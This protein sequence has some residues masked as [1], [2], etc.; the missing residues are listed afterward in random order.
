MSKERIAFN[1]ALQ[2]EKTYKAFIDQNG[3][4]EEINIPV[5]LN[6]PSN[7]LDIDPFMKRLED[8]FN[9]CE[10]LLKRNNITFENIAVSTNIGFLCK[11]SFVNRITDLSRR[12]D[13]L[14]RNLPLDNIESD[15]M[16]SLINDIHYLIITSLLPNI[17][18]KYVPV[19]FRLNLS[20]CSNPSNEIASASS[21]ED[22][23]KT[24]HEID[25]FIKN[26]SVKGIVDFGLLSYNLSENGFTSII[27]SGRC[28]TVPGNVEKYYITYIRGFNKK[29]CKS[30]SHFT[31]TKNT[32]KDKKLTYVSKEKDNN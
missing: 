28:T 31:I 29:D 32:G 24:Y 2:K 1:N 15:E 14:K 26:R 4:F 8:Y 13:G 20:K 3:S 11:E 27:K 12:L 22:Y 19:E 16:S 30:H 7:S 18:R 9:E 10:E 6:D 23:A 21:N 5:D 17:N 25:E